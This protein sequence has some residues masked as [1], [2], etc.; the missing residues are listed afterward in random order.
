[1]RLGAEAREV[2]RLMATL[3]AEVKAAIRDVSDYPKKGFVGFKDLT[4]LWKEGPLTKRTVDALY[5]YSKGKKLDKVVGI[6]AR[7]FIVGAPLADRLGIGFIPGRKLGKLPSRKLS[8]D[9]KLEYGKD[10]L[11]IHS[12]AISKDDRVLIVDDLLATGGT[13]N[14]ARILVEK[15]GGMVV[16]FAFIVELTYLKGRDKLGG[17]EIYSLARYDSE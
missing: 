3:E 11:E 13:A 8:V 16:G 9:Y 15:M 12:D 1:M 6:E 4:T 17:Y 7:G 14:A 5:E 2:E 10:G